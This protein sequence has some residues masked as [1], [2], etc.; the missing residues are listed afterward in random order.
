MPSSKAVEVFLLS[1]K[2]FNYFLTDEP[3]FILGGGGGC[4]GRTD[5]ELFME[6]YGVKSKL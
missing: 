2:K 5:Q 6:Q 4:R 3:M 1:W